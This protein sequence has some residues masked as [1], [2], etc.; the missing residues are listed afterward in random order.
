MNK[1]RTYGDCGVAT[2]LNALR[3]NG[4]TYFEGPGGYERLIDAIGRQNG[5][6]IQEIQAF[7]F[8]HSNKLPVYIPFEGF[9]KAS[10]IA[11]AFTSGAHNP[12][13]FN[14]DISSQKAIL[15]VMTKSGILHFVYY[16]GD[17]VWDPSQS[18]RDYPDFSDYE[19]I[20][21][22]VLLLDRPRSLVKKSTLNAVI[23]LVVSVVWNVKA[24]LGYKCYKIKRQIGEW[25]TK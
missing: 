15:Q 21:D 24:R 12:H 10:G 1:Q 5:L 22:A 7:L 13:E 18:A 16:D 8:M 19:Y 25:A 20:V 2:L 14:T 4:E 23:D 6:S 9:K 11:D 3:D 17:F